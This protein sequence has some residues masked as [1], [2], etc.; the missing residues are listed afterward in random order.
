[1][2]DFSYIQILSIFAIVAFASILRTFTGFGFALAAV[3]MFSLFL[4]PSESVVLS[5]TLIFLLSL[6]SIKSYW[7]VVPLAP[8]LPIGSMV[9]V[10]T[11]IGS[12]MLILISKSQFQTCVGLAVVAACFGLVYLKPS[13]KLK[14]H[15]LS[16]MTGL[17]SGI[18]NGAVAMSGPPMIAYAMLTEP[19]PK[20]SRA[21]LMTALGMA[22]LFGLISFGFAGLITQNTIWYALI[23]FPAL[24]VGN[25]LGSYLFQ[26]FG[27][28]FYRRTALLVLVIIGLATTSSGLLN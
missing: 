14:S 24:H 7:G 27:D 12:T 23:S 3:P 8:M 20:H 4:S 11:F 17:T 26:R 28:S 22:S 21:W 25:K 1:M 10:G 16:I 18:M 13:R 19:D 6:V 9:L 5:T 15:T 2:I